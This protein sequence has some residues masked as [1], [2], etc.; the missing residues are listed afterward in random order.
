MTVAGNFCI[1]TARLQIR[2]FVAEDIDFLVRLL[3]DA[4]TMS[5]W[6]QPLDAAQASDWLQRALD[7]YAAHGFG[8]ALVVLKDGA[9]P[10]GDVGIQRLSISTGSAGDRFENDLGYI[11]HRDHWG[12]GLGFE[13]ARACV[14]WARER[15]LESVVANMAQDNLPSIRVAE[16]LGMR[17]ESTFAN[18]RNAGKP[19]RLY[20]LVLN[21][22][23]AG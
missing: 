7:S 12:R 3:G 2:R 10:I 17:L 15:G 22:P 5:H 23:W 18:P 20:R 14:Q 16:N 19:T 4:Q 8:R 13:A 9:V 21:A 11:I 1:E 6:P